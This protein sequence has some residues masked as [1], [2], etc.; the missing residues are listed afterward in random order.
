MTDEEMEKTIRFILG[1]QAQFASDLQQMELRMQ[2]F[3]EQM[4][5]L[6]D[7]VI[8]V[9]GLVGKI[10]EAQIK[11]AEAQAKTDARVAELAEK[12]RETEERLNTFIVAVERYISERRN[13][14]KGNDE[15]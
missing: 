1:Q 12:G 3:Q 7:A 13:G 4:G 6:A 8:T 14:H 11:T 5:K 9:T 2:Q 10:G 15:R